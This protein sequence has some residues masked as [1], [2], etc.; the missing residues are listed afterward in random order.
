M[1]FLLDVFMS[2]PSGCHSGNLTCRIYT[3]GSMDAW[4]EAE[5]S[6]KETTLLSIHK[7]QS[8][9]KKTRKPEH[10]RLCLQHHM[11]HTFSLGEKLNRTTH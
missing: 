9:L 5:F 2:G 4:R 7:Y 3:L 10:L 1:M 8:P 11:L 6:E